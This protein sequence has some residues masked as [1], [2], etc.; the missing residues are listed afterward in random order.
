MCNC[1]MEMYLEVNSKDSMKR[2][3]DKRVAT[4]RERAGDHAFEIRPYF[5]KCIFVD[6]GINTTI[7]AVELYQLSV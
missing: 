6:F 4:L 1:L 2:D 3:F 5:P 7:G